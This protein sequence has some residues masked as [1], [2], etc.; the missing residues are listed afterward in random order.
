MARLPLAQ[1][2]ANRERAE[3]EAATIVQRLLR[4]N[5][6]L[7]RIASEYRVDGP[8]IRALYHA[9]TTA[10]ERNAAAGRKRLAS[11]TSKAF[12]KGRHVCTWTRGRKGARTW[13]KH[14]QKMWVPVGTV[15]IR[16]HHGKPVKFIKVN[17]GEAKS[18]RWA[19]LSHEVW[20]DANGPIPPGHAVGFRDGDPMNV[21]LENLILINRGKQLQELLRDPVVRARRAANLR[22]TLET[23]SQH[24]TGV[25]ARYR[26]VRGP[27]R[28]WLE[29]AGCGGVVDAAEIPDKCPKCQGRKFIK[30]TQRA[31]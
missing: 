24:R 27:M 23:V 3:A 1:C 13:M 2:R 6:T 29:C 12:R 25:P 9:A 20:E 30:I 11:P 26:E 5:I 21:V 22:R 14:G 4:T 8:V 7:A 28:S 17:D 18:K 31:A 19:R 16:N 15:K 10:A